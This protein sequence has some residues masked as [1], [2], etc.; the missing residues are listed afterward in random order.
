[1]LELM[2]IIE[3]NSKF[4]GKHF[5]ASVIFGASIEN[6]KRALYNRYYIINIE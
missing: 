1:M 5:A 6:Q 2:K 3:L 4:I